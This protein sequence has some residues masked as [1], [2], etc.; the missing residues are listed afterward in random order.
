VGKMSTAYKTIL[1]YSQ[2]PSLQQPPRLRQYR[3]HLSLRQHLCHRF[4][5]SQHLPPRQHQFLQRHLPPQLMSGTGMKL[6]GV[7]MWN[8][9]SLPS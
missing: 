8:S 4:Q 9:P 2:R 6:P 3:Q 5:Y 1:L 7:T